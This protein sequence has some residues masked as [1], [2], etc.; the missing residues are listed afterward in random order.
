MNQLV[1]ENTPSWNEVTQAV[2]KLNRSELLHRLAATA[3]NLDN[4]SHNMSREFIS[5]WGIAALARESILYGNELRSK[6]VT[7]KAFIELFNLFNVAG[8][9]DGC[10]RRELQLI[11]GAYMYE[12]IKFQMTP[13]YEI[14]RTYLLFGDQQLAA[15]HLPQLD[16]HDVF[17]MSL[18]ERMQAVF[19]ISV[20]MEENGGTITQTD[21]ILPKDLACKIGLTNE[22]FE[23]TVKDL[24]ATIQNAREA[25][26]PNAELGELQKRFAPSP[27]ARYP[28][29]DLGNGTLVAP[30]HFYILHTMTIGNLFYRGTKTWDGFPEELGK[31]VEAYTGLQLKSAGFDKVLPEIDYGYKSPMLSIDWF[32]QIGDTVILVECKSAKI[33]AEAIAGSARIEKVLENSIG[34]ARK[35]IKTSSQHI[36]KEHPKFHEI[37]KNLNQIGLIVTAEPIHCANA[38]DFHGHLTDP[39]IPCLTVSLR[40][41]EI[42]TALGADRMVRVIADI[43]NDPGE[44]EPWVVQNAIN[45]HSGLEAIPENRLILEAYERFVLPHIQDAE[46]INRG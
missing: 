10:S 9:A 36:L 19:A 34:K 35:Q 4:Y 26:P 40:E 29:I 28:L 33:P 8:K 32:A 6:P 7:V 16:W 21:G 45:K 17:G 18:Q 27:L 39:G 13:Q 25:F 37:P 41:L 43:V 22:Q 23:R 11:M 3:T 38:K 2:R 42:L 46:S 12:Q 14:A 31:R 20:A 44:A 5:P 1:L 15:P 30:Q 24:T